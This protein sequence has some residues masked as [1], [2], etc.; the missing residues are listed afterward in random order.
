MTKLVGQRHGLIGPW[1]RER[2]KASVWKQH[3]FFAIQQSGCTLVYL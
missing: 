3:L 2:D 1:Q